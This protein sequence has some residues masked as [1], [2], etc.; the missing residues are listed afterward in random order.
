MVTRTVSV[1]NNSLPR[2]LQ[3]PRE[4]GDASYDLIDV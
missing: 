1:M 2:G 4:R 3:S